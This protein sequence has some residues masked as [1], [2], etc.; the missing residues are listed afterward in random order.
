[1][2]VF[3]SCFCDCFGR[4]EKLKRLKTQI[5]S[6]L[7]DVSGDHVDGDRPRRSPLQDALIRKLWGLRGRKRFLQEYLADSSNVHPTTFDDDQDQ[8]DGADWA[9]DGEEDQPLL[10]EGRFADQ[11]FESIRQKCLEN[12]FLFVDPMF[13]PIPASLAQDEPGWGE[14]VEWV[15]A[16][17]LVEDPQLF[18]DGATRFDINQGTLGDCWLLAAM[19][20]LT[21][22]E[23]LRDR[24][25]PTDQGFTEEESYA[26]I[27]HFRFWQYG[28]WV[29]V[30]VD[31]YLPTKD[32][33]LVYISSKDKNEFWS[34]LL[35]K[36]YA[37]IH[38]SYKSLEGGSTADAMVDFSGGCSERY[39]LDDQSRW[40]E[41]YQV[42]YRAWQK[43]SSLMSCHLLPDPHVYEA[44]TETGLVRGHAYSVTKVLRAKVDT[45]NK[46]G[47]FPLVRIRNPWG[48]KEWNGTW[49]D[50]SAV[51]TF[52]SDEEKE[53][54]GLN[55]EHDGE[56]YMS[57]MD[58]MANFE[59]VEICNMGPEIEGVTGWHVQYSDGSWIKGLNAGGSRNNVH[60]FATNPQYMMTLTDSDEDEDD[61]CTCVVSLIQKGTRLRKAISDGN[62]C[63][64][65]G[66]ILYEYKSEDEEESPLLVDYFR[67][68]V[69]AGRSGT[70]SNSR[71][72]S[73]RFHLPP[74]KYVVIPS[75]FLP[76]LEGDFLLR[77][78]T[79]Q[80]ANLRLISPQN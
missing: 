6:L 31:D 22:I 61:M 72:V 40:M 23:E 57:Q 10:S 43:Q 54:I 49:S 45:G 28:E 8:T 56:F 9:E 52:V 70:F 41:I 11:D 16:S 58:F 79:E 25:V 17:E 29:D 51:W 13:P 78:F 36:A 66:F 63:L 3:K 46:K 30:V 59:Y 24:V 20:N 15:R 50:N 80:P 69:S 5:E 47:E 21:L 35:E 73:A 39:E 2:N 60:S 7:K 26:G 34:A 48:E 33:Q 76:D 62:G 65:I 4:E 32:G 68:N 67:F 77:V 75:T 18:V 64:V 55:F 19:A 1:L 12:N 71:E 74:G 44:R 27:F 53:R 14:G 37:K 42:M 38:G